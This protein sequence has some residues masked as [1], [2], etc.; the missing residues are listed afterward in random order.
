MS[1]LTANDV[2]NLVDGSDFSSAVTL[3][4]NTT[5]NGVLLRDFGESLEINGRSARLVLTPADAAGVAIAE[6]LTINSVGYTVRAIESG[7]N[8]TALILERN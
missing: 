2:Q 8:T 6:T 4:D 3:A 7:D 5:I 1:A